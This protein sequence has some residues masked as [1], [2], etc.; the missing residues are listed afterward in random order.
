VA[1]VVNVHE[2]LPF[3]SGLHES[4]QKVFYPQ[5]PAA[6]RFAVCSNIECSPISENCKHAAG[7]NGA[8]QAAKKQDRELKGP[9]KA[10]KARGADNRRASQNAANSRG[11]QLIWG[12]D[13]SIRRSRVERAVPPIYFPACGLDCMAMAPDDEHPEKA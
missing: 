10:I 8:P 12:G 6:P 4:R 9:Q 7:D 1:N 11:E 13:A 5:S 2:T 3:S